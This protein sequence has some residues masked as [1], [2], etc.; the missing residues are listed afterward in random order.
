MQTPELNMNG[1]SGHFKREVKIMAGLFIAV[2][3]LGALAAWHVPIVMDHGAEARCQTSGGSFNYETHSCEHP[4][5]V[6]R[7]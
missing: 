6:L 4:K 7:P 5:L 1:I 2:V 3:V